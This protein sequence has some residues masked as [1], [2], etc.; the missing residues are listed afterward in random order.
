MTTIGNSS[1][2]D[3]MRLQQ[4]RFAQQTGTQ[5]GVNYPEAETTIFDSE[6]GT[7]NATTL[8]NVI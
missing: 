8:E 4:T 3:A 2:E 1:Y 7:E 5:E 6:I